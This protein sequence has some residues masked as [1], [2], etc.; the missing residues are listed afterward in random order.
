MTEDTR[1]VAVS[2]TRKLNLGNYE[3]VDIFFA[4]SGLEVGVT[5][6]EIEDCLEVGERAYEAIRKKI[7]AKTGEIKQF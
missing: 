6:E 1:R 7:I 3:S 4:I 2:A 5:D